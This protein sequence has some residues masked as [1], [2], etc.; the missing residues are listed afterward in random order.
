M[1][2]RNESWFATASRHASV[3][4]SSSC[5]AARRASGGGPALSSSAA[6]HSSARRGSSSNVSQRPERLL[7]GGD[8]DKLLAHRARVGDERLHDSFVGRGGELALQPARPLRHERLQPTAPLARRLDAHE[9]IS[10]VVVSGPAEIVLRARD[11]GVEHAQA[12]A[13]FG[14]FARQLPAPRAATTEPCREHLDVASGEVEPDLLELSREPVVATRGIGLALEGP[15]L[16]AHLAEQV[17]EPEQVRLGR[18]EPA[19]GLLLALAVLED[20]RGLFDDGAAVF[21]PRVEHGVELALPDDDVL[22]AADAG[23]GEELLQVEQAA[24]RAVDRVLRLTGAEEGAGDRHLGE[25]DRQQVRRVVDRERDLGASERGAIGG[26]G[27]DDVVH[28]AAAQRPRALRAE[29]PRDRVDEVR[30]P[31][32]VRADDHRDSGLEVEGRLLRERLEPFE[33]QRFQEHWR[34]I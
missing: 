21:R 31:R 26:T 10:D 2:A 29:H 11:V 3:A 30:L 4:S 24:R 34:R 6:R 1:R 23:V 13:H 27:E 33:G 32:A 17:G 28:L 9:Q 18:L 19:L 5:S 15:Q 7:V 16:A 14:F 22:L 25:L 12:G 20:A 8:G